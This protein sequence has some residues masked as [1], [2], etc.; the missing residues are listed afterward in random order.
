MITNLNNLYKLIATLLFLFTIILFDLH[1]LAA[2]RTKPAM[3]PLGNTNRYDFRCSF[4]NGDYY[5]GSIYASPEKNY[6][7][8]YQQY[9]TD[10]TGQSV[11][12]KI[13]AMGTGYSQPDGDVYVSSYYDSETHNSYTPVHHGS[14]VGQSYLGSESDYILNKNYS[15]EVVD[16]AA[17]IKE[18][19]FGYGGPALA[20]RIYEADVADIYNV[21][22]FGAKADGLTDDSGAIQ[23]TVNAAYAQGGGFIIFPGGVYSVITVNI[24]EGIT[25]Y[26]DGAMIKRP[27]MQPYATRTFNTRV[28]KIF[29]CDRFQTI[30]Y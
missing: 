20:G 5:L 2:V 19:K 27:D 17:G 12:Y 22:D 21:K 18:F 3:P 7:V 24:R 25:Y 16:I 26:G 8:G 15:A 14:A 6:Y 1:C 29:R 10:E 4:A 23:R 11:L 28:L 9:L 30:T 13:T